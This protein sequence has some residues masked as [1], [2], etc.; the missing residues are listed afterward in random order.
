[1]LVLT[2]FTTAFLVHS[3]ISA[4]RYQ[5]RINSQIQQFEYNQA[6]QQQRQ[7]LQ[8]EQKLKIQQKQIN[9]LKKQVSLKRQKQAELARLASAEATQSLATPQV[10][11]YTA[12]GNCAAYE[13]L[14]KQ[15]AWNVSI[16]LAVMHAES[17][18]NTTAT[19]PT[20]DH[21]LMQVNCVH[22]NLVSGNLALLNDPATNIKVAYEVYQGAGW[23]AWTTYTSGAYLS[24]L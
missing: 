17:H 15:Y 2:A 12:A 6:Q 16:A 1:M 24:Y 22:S 3:T 4:N 5:E 18:C 21:G 10:A 9:D 19:S 8:L 20:C 13:P 23:S 14:L 7:Q 11:S